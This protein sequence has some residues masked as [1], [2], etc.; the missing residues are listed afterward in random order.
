MKIFIDATFK[1]AVRLIVDGILLL[2]IGFISSS[3]LALPAIM[4]QVILVSVFFYEKI[5]LADIK[6]DKLREEIEREFPVPDGI[7]SFIIILDFVWSNLR[8]LASITFFTLAFSAGIVL[9]EAM[10]NQINIINLFSICS[11]VFVA[12]LIGC[13]S[14]ALI[15]NLIKQD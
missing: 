3:A 8:N 14:G 11:L 2:M 5:F 1:G 4:I 12:V 9:N 6:G 7:I 10:L 13:F 15:G